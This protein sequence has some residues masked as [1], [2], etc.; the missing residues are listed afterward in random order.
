MCAFVK[1]GY[2]HVSIPLPLEFSHLEVLCFDMLCNAFKHRFICV[3]RPPDYDLIRTVDRGAGT[4]GHG[5]A[6]APP[7]QFKFWRGTVGHK[8]ENQ[9][10]KNQ[11]YKTII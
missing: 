4:V 2:S 5:G 3:Y 11:Y 9:R 1:H 6:H 8:N 10:H 7:P